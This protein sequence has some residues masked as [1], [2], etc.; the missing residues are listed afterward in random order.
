MIKKLKYG[1]SHIS[2]KKSEDQYAVLSNGGDKQVLTLNRVNGKGTVDAEI[3]HLMKQKDFVSKHNTAQNV[4]YFADDTLNN[5]VVPTGEIYVLFTKEVDIKKFIKDNKLTLVEER[6]KSKEFIFKTDDNVIDICMKYQ[7]DEN[8]SVIEPD[9]AYPMIHFCDAAYSDQP[10]QKMNELSSEQWHLRNTGEG[11]SVYPAN[12]FKAGADCGVMDAWEEI[13]KKN[14]SQDKQYGAG[15]TIAIIDDGFD[16]G[17][18]SFR[19]G[20]KSKIVGKYDA[21]TKTNTAPYGS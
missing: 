15:I 2:L 12:L 20:D 3:A 4:F 17:H 1:S 7:D 5:P 11:N 13:I 10:V 21:K 19:K 8:I 18:E 14:L 16:A 9:L 6:D